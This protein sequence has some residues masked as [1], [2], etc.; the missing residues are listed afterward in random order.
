MDESLAKNLIESQGYEVEDIKF[1]PEGRNHFCFDV[2]LKDGSS[3]IARF[4]RD[5]IDGKKRD[6][7][8]N[9]FLSLE[10]ER[11]LCN[12][13]REEA[14]LPAPKIN[15]LYGISKDSFLLVEKL[16]GKSW[17]EY[18]QEKNYQLGPFLK[19]LEFLGEDLAQVQRINF[20]SY[21]DVIDR[22]FIQPYGIYNF[23]DRLKTITNLKLQRAK[24]SNVLTMPELSE[25]DKYFR[26]NFD[27]IDKKLQ[28]HEEKPVLILTDIHPMNFLV[29]MNGKPS[30]YPDLEWCQSGIPSL[31]FY[32][33]KYGLFNY[34]DND[35]FDKAE[36]AF[37]R[38]F[39]NNG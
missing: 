9:G 32:I 28:F 25:V 21:G 11:N 33:L 24:K 38:G 6:F 18:I 31:E 39:R 29:D 10:R 22:N 5:N 36:D 16:P 23:T 8:Y 2:L 30:G 13:L 4:E 12:I 34:F 1:I 17:K 20:E 3:T 37:F 35:T 19:S 26:Q 27:F 7:H 15:G 14:K